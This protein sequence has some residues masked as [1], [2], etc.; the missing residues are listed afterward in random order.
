MRSYSI[1]SHPASDEIELCV[2]LLPG[3]V[4]STFFEQV[5]PETEIRF[6]GSRGR[7]VVGDSAEP[8]YFVATGAGLAPIM[9][10]I[11]DELIN[12]KN[13]EPIEL[14]FGVRSEEDIF[15]TDRLDALQ[16]E[17][18]NFHYRLTLSQP[19]SAWAG[20]SGRVST[21]N[22]IFHLTILS[23]AVRRW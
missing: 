20:L 11:A 14:L 12:K 8:L 4:G 2:K 21:S 10:M 5:T 17:Y 7:F 16:K 19:R 1:A 3:G 15:W 23:A 22:Q 13:T 18:S 9:G 6:I